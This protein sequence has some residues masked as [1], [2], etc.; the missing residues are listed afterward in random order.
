MFLLFMSEK[1]NDP[2]LIPNNKSYAFA[3]FFK[4]KNSGFAG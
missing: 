2:W 1:S 3:A 4:R